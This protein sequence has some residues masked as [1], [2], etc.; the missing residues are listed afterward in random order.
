MKHLACIMDGNRRWAREQGCSQFVAYQKGLKIVELAIDFCIT[1]GIDYLSL[2]L[3]SIQNMQRTPQE[4]EVIFLLMEQAVDEALSF[5][6][7]H[8]VRVFF[9]GNLLLFPSHIQDM[10]SHVQEQTKHATGLQLTLLFGYGAQEDIVQAVQSIVNDVHKGLVAKENITQDV[11]ISYL[12]TRHLPPPDVIMRTGDVTR[13]SNCLLYQAAYTELYFVPVMWPS[14]TLEHFEAMYMFF[15]N[16]KRNF[17][18]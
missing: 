15:T 16:T 12:W 7:K 17:G 14:L 13:L 5:A 1:K 18:L 3:F 4:K 8:N 6:V 9:S 10:C 2:F 11:V